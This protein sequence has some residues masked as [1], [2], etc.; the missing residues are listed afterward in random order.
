[1]WVRAMIRTRSLRGLCA[2]LALCAGSAALAPVRAQT[3][4]GPAEATADEADV[5]FRLGNQAYKKRDFHQAL[6]HY[7][8]SNRM[9]PNRNVIFN[10]ARCYEQLKR[11]AEAFRYYQLF[12]G[13]DLSAAERKA[14]TEALERVRPLVALLHVTSQ[15]PGAV[16]YIKRKDLGSYGVTPAVLAFRPGSY[17]VLLEM[18]G[19]KPWSRE[20]VQLS[21]GHETRL[22]ASLERIV[23]RLRLEGSPEGAMVRIEAPEGTRTGSLP[24]EAELAPGA[25]KVFVSAEG[26]ELAERAVEVS[27]GQLRSERIDLQA[28]LGTLLVQSDEKDALI[29]V[30]G[31]P[32]GF[33]PAV[34]DKL[35]V[36]EHEIT[37][38]QDGF[39]DFRRR[40]R[41][42][43]DRKVIVD[44]QLDVSDDVAAASRSTESLLDA[45][46][47]VSLISRREIDAFAYTDLTDALRGVRGAFVTDDLTYATV[48]IRGFSRFGQY[49]NRVLVQLDGHTLNDD[50][51]G[52]S[53]VE[54]DLM[55]DLQAIERIELVRGPGS[56][57]YGTGAFFGVINLVSPPAAD[58]QIYHVGLS[59]PAP[60]VFRAH[61]ARGLSFAEHDAGF[62]V[63]AGYLFGQ[64]FDFFSPVQLGSET[65]P[66]GVARD[67]GAND[68][69]TVMAKGSWRDL[70]LQGYYHHRD[71][72]IPTGSFETIFG[73]EKTHTND[74]RGFAELRYEPRFGEVFQLLGRLYYDHYD[75]DG[76]FPY[77]EEDY[78][79]VSREYYRGDWAGA[80]LRGVLTPGW[81]LRLTAGSSF[82]WHFHNPGYGSDDGEDEPFY[83][84]VHPFQALSAYLVADYAPLDWLR[85]SGGG[86]FD[87]WWIEDLADGSGGTDRRFLY[88]V[89]PRLALIFR[90]TPDDILKT[91][92]GTAFRAPSL[93]EMTY[94]DGGNTQVQSLDLQPERIITGELEYTRRLPEGF[95]LTASVFL[96]RISDLIEQIGEGVSEDPLRYRNLD[97]T[98]WTLG[99]EIELR[100]EFR[101][102]W[103]LSA[104]YSY[105]RTRLADIAD[106]QEPANSP[107]HLAGARLLVPV[108]GRSLRLATRLAVAAGRLDR[109]GERTEPVVMWD[110]M[111]S[112]QVEAWRMHYAFGARNLLGWRYSYPTG[113]D[114]PDPRLRQRG[115]CL[116]AELG[117][118]L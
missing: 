31:R 60:G 22:E 33:T 112:G 29:L 98:L 102:G 105:Q 30:D 84:E 117:F 115:L 11:Y 68:A 118:R 26:F 78:R 88:S 39:R 108:I 47:S 32:A 21:L 2:A 41:V 76:A 99:G 19:H 6:S 100:K 34:L 63:S 82:E 66:D 57:L 80:E 52:S 97:E 72:Q 36:G 79:Y 83:D 49:G 89:N 107:E 4:Q 42:E 14:L 17:R 50:W 16:V 77:D 28:R 23:G 109:E 54:Y 48:G 27:E 10:I 70:S 58:E 90:L 64:G 56:A 114:V 103:M 93:Y 9:A 116:V 104:Q 40:V 18:K 12:D 55:T 65:H 7:F 81:G 44:A 69:W 92:G 111:L 8:A 62:W 74:S 37:V 24:M 113:E 5:R 71:K 20:G 25:V 86:R 85:L 94:W 96:N 43:A 67:V 73:S 15:P 46:A 61:A 101:R 91:M 53:Y 1:M 38:R 95:W 87:G 3:A 13:S 110:L 59:T 106:S 45:P 75:Y 35:A 51:I